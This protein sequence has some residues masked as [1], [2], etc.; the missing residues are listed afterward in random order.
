MGY[1][2]EKLSEFPAL[3]V[4]FLLR[5]TDSKLVKR[6]IY[7]ILGGVESYKEKTNKEQYRW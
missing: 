7:I 6:K 2:S 4:H 5:E 1:N 3:T